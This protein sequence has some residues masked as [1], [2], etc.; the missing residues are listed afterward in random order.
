MGSATMM[1]GSEIAALYEAMVGITD[2]MLA[3]AAASD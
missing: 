1:T 2:Q 3:A